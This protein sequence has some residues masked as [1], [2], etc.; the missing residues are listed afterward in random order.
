MIGLRKWGEG[1]GRDV[2][3]VEE[4]SIGLTV[5]GHVVVAI[6]VERAT[7]EAIELIEESAAF[8]QVTGDYVYAIVG[9]KEL[10][11]ALG[12]Q[13]SDW[14]TDDDKCFVILDDKTVVVL[15]GLFE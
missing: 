14:V 10:Y 13:V 2:C 4:D 7:D 8:M 12:K 6:D 9:V 15:H 3:E 5:N 1:P 11:Q